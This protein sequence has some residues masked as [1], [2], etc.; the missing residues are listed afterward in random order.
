MSRL[1]RVASFNVNGIRARLPLLVSWLRDRG[2]EVVCLQETKVQDTDFPL[3]ALEELGYGCVFR[4]QRCFNGVAILN[5]EHQGFVRAGLD[6][7]G[8]PDEPRLVLV[9]MGEVALLGC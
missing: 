4:G 8:S 3:E 6:D 2:P 5:R 1:L 7:E 9:R